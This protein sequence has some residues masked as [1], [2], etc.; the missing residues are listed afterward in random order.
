MNIPAM[1]RVT[2]LKRTFEEK[3]DGWGEPCE[4]LVALDAVHAIRQGPGVTAIVMTTGLN[5]GLETFHVS[6]T[7]EEI[8]LQIEALRRL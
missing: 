5:Q 1:I 8:I 6:Q 4:M 2:R 7:L 3:G